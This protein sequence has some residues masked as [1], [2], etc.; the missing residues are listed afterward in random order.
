MFGAG[1]EIRGV[2]QFEIIKVEFIIAEDVEDFPTERGVDI[3]VF[4][5]V[6]AVV[7]LNDQF[8]Q[9]EGPGIQARVED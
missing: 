6:E 9:K 1:V 4:L 2:R 5:K 3:A 7:N 8:S